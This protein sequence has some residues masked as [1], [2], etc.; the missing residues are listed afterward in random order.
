[1]KVFQNQQSGLNGQQGTALKGWNEG[2]TPCAAGEKKKEYILFASR[3]H[4]PS[5]IPRFILYLLLK[6][7]V[8]RNW[9]SFNSEL[10]AHHWH[11]LDKVTTDASLQHDFFPVL[12]QWEPHKFKRNRMILFILY[13]PFKVQVP[14]AENIVIIRKFLL[15]NTNYLIY[16]NFIWRILLKA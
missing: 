14:T 13:P 11:L 15:Y 7:K 8:K 6:Q 16:C 2:R 3:I 1:M 5:N 12:K 9:I 4:S 10:G